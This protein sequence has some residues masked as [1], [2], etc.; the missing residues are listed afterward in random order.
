MPQ[1]GFTHPT[2]DDPRRQALSIW[3]ACFSC[4]QEGYIARDCPLGE[5][6]QILKVQE[7]KTEMEAQSGKDQP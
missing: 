4:G 2:Y 5:K 7:V 3:G 6:G 1:T